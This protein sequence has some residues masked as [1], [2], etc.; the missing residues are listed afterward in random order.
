MKANQL[1]DKIVLPLT[2]TIASSNTTSD[3]V[4][5]FGTT[6][7]AFQTPSALTGTAFT[8]EGSIDAGVTFKEIRDQA[9]AA[10]SF[11]VAPDGT[12]PLD[13]NLFAPY[14]EIKIVSGSSEA[15][16]RLILIKPFVI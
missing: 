7:I 8:F 13:A 5:L 11:V 9:G 1:L 16:E 10:V 2:A 14:D 4:E 12:Y 15:A 3:A 6:A